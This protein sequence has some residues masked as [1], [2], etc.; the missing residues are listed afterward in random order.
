MLTAEYLRQIIH[1]DPETGVF[2]RDGKVAG[3]IS[4]DGYRYI[5]IDYVGYLE[6]RLAVLYVTGQLPKFGVSHRNYNRA[7]NRWTNLRSA[8]AAQRARSRKATNKLGIKGVRMTPQGNYRAVIYVKGR[9]RHLGTFP[10]LE[11]ASEAY[12]EAAR[13]HFGEFARAS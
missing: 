8:T 4:G 3:G 10:T 7:D 1:Y 11:A 2:T 13:E 12:L 5:T 9:N 6:H